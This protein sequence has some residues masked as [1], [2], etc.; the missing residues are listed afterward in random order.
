MFGKRK[1]EVCKREEDS[2]NVRRLIRARVL[3]ALHQLD[4]LARRKDKAYQSDHQLRACIA[5][6][7]LAPQMLG[8]TRSGRR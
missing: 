4:R 3:H 6:V 2:D 5:L 8:P 1:P 7:R